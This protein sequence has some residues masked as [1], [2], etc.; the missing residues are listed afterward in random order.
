MIGVCAGGRKADVGASSVPALLRTR[1]QPDDV[2]RV[3]GIAAN[4]PVEPRGAVD[5]V[6]L[7]PRRAGVVA[8]VCAAGIAARVDNSVDRV[9][10]RATDAQADAAEFTG[11]QA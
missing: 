4:L 2:V 3:G 8:A 11:G 10:T 9:G 7:P 5:V 1:R 6:R